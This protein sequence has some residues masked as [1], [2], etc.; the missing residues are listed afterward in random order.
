M[1]TLWSRLLFVLQYVVDPMHR[2]GSLRTLR[3]QKATVRMRMHTLTVCWSLGRNRMLVDVVR[4]RR[5]QWYRLVEVFIKLERGL[6][7]PSARLLRWYPPQ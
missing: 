6:Q 1:P 3:L 2:F 4:Y 5:K 7:S